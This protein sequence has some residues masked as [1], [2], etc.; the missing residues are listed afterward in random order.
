MYV[1]Q[2]SKFDSIYLISRET[3]ISKKISYHIR[4]NTM[5]LRIDKHLSTS[6]DFGL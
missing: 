6:R 1:I 5:F 2:L 3:F 4:V